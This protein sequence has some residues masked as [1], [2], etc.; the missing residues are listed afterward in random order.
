MLRRYQS[1]LG[2][3]RGTG[4]G[5]EHSA[6]RVMLVGR[7]TTGCPEDA[8]C[9]VLTPSRY[10]RL[11]KEG[12]WV[13]TG[14]ICS[15]LGSLVLVRVLTEY[16]EPVQ[17]GQIALGLT[18]AAL[19]NQAVLGGLTNGISRFFSIASEREDLRGYLRAS[20]RLMALATLL[21]SAIGV[22][23]LLGL[24]L[25]DYSRWI[26]LALAALVFAVLSGFSGAISAIQN[27]ARQ[28]AVVAFHGGLDAWLKILLAVAAMRWLGNSSTAVML[29]YAGSSLLVTCSQLLFM[30]RLIWTKTARV[31]SS[32]SWSSQIWE[33][34]WPFSIF[35]IFTWAQQ[36]SDRWA[37]EAFADT[38]GVGLYAVLFQLGYTPIATATSFAV[39]FVA[40]I[41]Y[42]RS[43]DATSDSR[44]A[45]VHRL[46]SYLTLFCLMLTLMAFAVALGLHEWIFRLLV[47]A[48][49]RSVSHL[50][51]WVV[52]AGGL[53][54]AAQMLALKLMTDLRS[55]AMIGAKVVTAIL[56]ILFNIYGASVAGLTGIAIS[57]VAF[58]VVHFLWMLQLSRPRIATGRA[59]GLQ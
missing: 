4:L 26:G 27:A 48:E 33:F 53:F 2:G 3:R 8:E 34:S 44:N 57:G 52:L 28:R 22:L 59:V 55:G 1:G 39:S 30:R 58:S 38:Q 56:G 20:S 31:A 24:F 40:P 16:L 6:L 41:L 11:A 35:G 7:R 37:L 36:S 29:G 9:S 10:F 42:Q 49:F 54:A 5:C 43:G 19:V 47:A 14:Q 51:P 45:H 17:Y 32:A 12:T 15:V 46:T 23:L 18:V 21:V 25:L 50:L 13:A